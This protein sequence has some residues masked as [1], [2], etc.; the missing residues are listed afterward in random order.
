MS[1]LARR[2]RARMWPLPPATSTMV[3]V[4]GKAYRSTSPS[5]NGTARRLM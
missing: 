5:V 4:A 2:T 1:G 3:A